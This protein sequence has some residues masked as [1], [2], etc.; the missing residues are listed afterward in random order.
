VPGRVGL[1]ARIG[2]RFAAA[3]LVEHQDLVSFRVELPAV[4]GARAAAR[5]AVEEHHG[6]AVG[7]ARKL[8]VEGMAVADIEHAALIGFDRGIERPARAGVNVHQ[9]LNSS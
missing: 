3:A 1:E 4:V 8:P 7:V 2:R 6:L 9:K 5:S